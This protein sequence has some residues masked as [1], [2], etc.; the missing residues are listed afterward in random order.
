MANRGWYNS[1][2]GRFSEVRWYLNLELDSKFGT[3]NLTATEPSGLGSVQVR[4]W[5]RTRPR[6]HYSVLISG[7]ENPPA[8]FASESISRIFRRIL[9]VLYLAF[10]AETFLALCPR[11]P[12]AK[13]T[14]NPP[15][16][17]FHFSIS[18]KC[19]PNLE[20]CALGTRARVGLRL[21]VQSALQEVAAS[22][23]KAVSPRDETALPDSRRFCFNRSITQVQI[24]GGRAPF[25]LA[26]HLL[27]PNI[28]KARMLFP[29]LTSTQRKQNESLK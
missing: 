25:S 14:R 21:R 23:G 1:D 13:L 20:I 6:K 15:H 8:G 16:F 19:S 3:V 29:L 11:Y 12:F 27:A 24:L 7:W 17:T 18:R 28:A 10:V 22:R 9:L 2:S 4:Q 5:F 26:S